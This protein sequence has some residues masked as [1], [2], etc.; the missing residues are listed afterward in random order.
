[1]LSP[2]DVWGY[3]GIRLR[4]F[5]V[6]LDI[7]GQ[8]HA[9]VALSRGRDHGYPLCKKTF[10]SMAGLDDVEKKIMPCRRLVSNP[11]SIALSY[12][13]CA[14]PPPYTD[15]TLTKSCLVLLAVVWG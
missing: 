15:T 12:T 5:T 13:D 4:F 3:G 9:P 6:V 1:V 2:E 8:F 11:G 7:D 10:D 14:I